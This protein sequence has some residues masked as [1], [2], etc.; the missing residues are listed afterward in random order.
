MGTIPTMKLSKNPVF[1]RH[2]IQIEEALSKTS[3]QVQE[4]GRRLFDTMLMAAEELDLLIDPGT[5]NRPNPASISIKRDGFHKT[6]RDMGEWLRE[7]APDV[8]LT[9]D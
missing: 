7:H 4:S 2:Q 5:G 6:C 1:L 8:N 9:W 3:D